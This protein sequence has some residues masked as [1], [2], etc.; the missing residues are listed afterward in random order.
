[1]K[2]NN[3]I[4]DDD[5]SDDDYIPKKKVKIENTKKYDKIKK[6]I[7]E[8]D[9][10]MNNIL[11][12][13]LD[14]DDNI[15]FFEYF[16]ILDNIDEE[17]EER[18]RIKKMIYD[19]YISLKNTD[20]KLLKKIQ[21]ELIIDNDLVQRILNSK[22]SNEIKS[23]MYKKYKRCTETTN[24]N[25]DELF[26]IIDWINTIL[27]LPTNLENTNIDLNNLWKFLNKNVYGLMNVKEKVMETMCSKILNPECHG[28]ILTLVGS[29]GVGKTAM[30]Y[31]IAESMSLPFDQISF[32]SIKDSSV[33]TGH[34]STYIGAMPSLF[35]KILLKSKQLNMVILL[36][37]IDKI[38]DSVEGKSIS[39]VLLHILDKTQNYR[40]RDMYMPEINLDLSKILFICAANSLDDIDHVLRDRMT[41]IE[42]EGYTT[43]DKVNIIKNHIF[44]RIKQELNINNSD[45]IITN[46]KIKY[47]IENKTKN[48]SGMREIERKM[49]ELVEK[50]M[51]LKLS[52][53][54]FSFKLDDLKFPY[55]I[56]I[57]TINN[58]LI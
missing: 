27:E 29:P 16:K 7:D 5:Y 10:N 1:M 14:M 38:P 17:S 57:D 39:S 25:S 30:A 13:D 53:I 28:K 31:S 55:K 45:I 48:E 42:I 36:D 40:F 3:F 22:Q 35:T 21:T 46:K 9:I 58:L 23:I 18:F 26:K 54:Q 4:V 41:I 20:L 8:R 37:E 33:L 51:L 44:P 50:I 49:Y 34:S 15:W 52:N 47:I 6:E 56:S 24:S 12:L 11:K 43:F 19:K 2:K 32:G